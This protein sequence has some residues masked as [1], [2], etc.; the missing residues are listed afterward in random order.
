MAGGIAAY[1]WQNQSL[2]K[3]QDEHFAEM[4][5]TIDEAG[6]G[7]EF[8]KN[9]YRDAVMQ[10]SM[11]FNLLQKIQA[12]GNIGMEFP[13]EMPEDADTAGIIAGVKRYLT[14]AAVIRYPVSVSDNKVGKAIS[15]DESV[16]SLD[17][18]RPKTL[19]EAVYDAGDG[20][21]AFVFLSNHTDDDGAANFLL[22]RL[23]EAGM[24]VHAAGFALV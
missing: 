22:P 17:S 10:M 4:D 13:D 9:A 2:P 23:T 21:E 12:A 7:F 24:T 5:E 8:L 20:L 14:Q 18:K 1:W 11:E 3:I 15:F 19:V 16:K 6:E